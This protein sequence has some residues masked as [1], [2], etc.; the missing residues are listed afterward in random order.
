[1]T[2]A[3]QSA[4]AQGG[5]AGESDEAR[6]GA[7][8]TSHPP[9]SPSTVVTMAGAGDDRAGGIVRLLPHDQ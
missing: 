6:A 2:T 9:D 4:T 3:Q 1:M 7:S 5:G 8:G